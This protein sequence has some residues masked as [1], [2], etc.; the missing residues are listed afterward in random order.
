MH[1]QYEVRSTKSDM[2]LDTCP[3]SNRRPLGAV[4][5]HT[6][7]NRIREFHVLV[8][9]ADDVDCFWTSAC[10]EIL[11]GHLSARFYW[12]PDALRP[13]LFEHGVTCQSTSGKGVSLS[14]AL[15]TRVCQLTL[16]WSR[17]SPPFLIPD[18]TSQELAHESY[19]GPEVSCEYHDSRPH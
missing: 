19:V 17:N 10:R 3:C 5:T 16:N 15:T 11:Q 9:R 8:F 13:W 6:A 18:G 1:T 7:C 2:R 4:M 14:T 12:H